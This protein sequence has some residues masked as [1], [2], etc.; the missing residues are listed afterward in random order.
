MHVADDARVQRTMRGTLAGAAHVTRAY[1]SRKINAAIAWRDTGSSGLNNGSPE[2]WVVPVEMP[3]SFIHA[4]AAAGG[5]STE[6]SAKDWPVG[7]AE[8]S[9]PEKRARNSAIACRDTGSVGLYKGFPLGC[10]V[11]VVIPRDAIHSIAV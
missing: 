6:T 9:T 4:M 8:R 10:K 3:R 2:G 11:P 1:W 5:L 7:A